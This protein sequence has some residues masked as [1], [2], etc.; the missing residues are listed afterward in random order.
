MF[1]RRGPWVGHPC[2][3]GD[4]HPLPGGPLP[5]Y[6]CGRNLLLQKD[7]EKIQQVVS[8]IICSLLR[9]DPSN[10]EDAVEIWEPVKRDTACHNQMETSGSKTGKEGEEDYE[11]NYEEN[12][13]IEQYGNVDIYTT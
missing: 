4:C 1:A 5:N 2:D 9:A 7:G 13:F 12:N 8:M 11:I 10:G 6:C 3:P